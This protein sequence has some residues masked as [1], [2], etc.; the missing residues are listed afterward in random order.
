[1]CRRSFSSHDNKNAYIWAGMTIER[2]K[3]GQG[4]F[5][6]TTR[7]TWASDG[8]LRVQEEL[9]KTQRSRVRGQ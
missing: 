5:S 7:K 4:R 8:V 2:G 3:E 6:G 1:M 9:K